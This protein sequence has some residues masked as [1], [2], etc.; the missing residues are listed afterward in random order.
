MKRCPQCYQPY[1]DTEIFCEK[2]GQRLLNVPV[3]RSSPNAIV[4]GVAGMF[5]G[6]VLCG[7]VY[8]AY[9]VLTPG[10]ATDERAH[11]Q[12]ETQ[13][14]ETSSQPR[15]APPRTAEPLPAPSESPTPDEAAAE[16]SPEPEQPQADTAAARFERGPVST[17]APASERTA[18]A[19]TQTIIEMKD[20]SVVEV[21]AAW[22]D[23]QGVWYRRGGLVSF[24]ES[25]RVKAITARPMEP[26]ESAVENK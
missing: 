11:A 7:G 25:P 17:G 2:D 1:E 14:R 19:K 13:T 22:K 12:L 16:A 10:V 6:A 21:D 18:D 26:K 20:G 24:V 4:I 3:R 15:Q 9:S 23:A 5:L 8:V